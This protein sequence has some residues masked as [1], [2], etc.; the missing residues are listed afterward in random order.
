[1]DCIKPLVKK[2]QLD[3][4]NKLENNQFFFLSNLLD[5]SGINVYEFRIFAHVYRRHECTSSVETMADICR[6]SERKIQQ[7]IR[8]LKRKNIFQIQIQN[9]PFSRKK[10][11]QKPNK[12]TINDI[13]DWIYIDEENKNGWIESRLRYPTM[14]YQQIMHNPP[15]LDLYGL[16]PY[17]FRILFHIAAASS[18]IDNTYKGGIKS[19]SETTKIGRRKIQYCLKELAVGTEDIPGFNILKIIHHKGKPSE[20]KIQNLSEWRLINTE[21]KEQ[22]RLIKERNNYIQKRLSQLSN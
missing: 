8:N 7:S 6:M 1:M 19:I 22:S 15:L 14:T 9:D 17:Q 13:N 10:Y 11:K 20:Y 5:D 16:N 12:I 2:V 4:F 3:L 21:T 18:G